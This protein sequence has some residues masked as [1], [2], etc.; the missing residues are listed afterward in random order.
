MCHL[1]HVGLYST[2]S[3]ESWENTYPIMFP[4]FLDGPN[5]N[6]YPI[7]SLFSWDSTMYFQLREFGVQN[8]FSV[9][10]H[11]VLRNLFWYF[12]VLMISSNVDVVLL[13]HVR[14]K[15]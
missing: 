8:Y 13:A 1:S 4:Y 6:N 3:S 9:Y 15:V 14:R 2:H 11:Y 12:R 5:S 10:C 7:T